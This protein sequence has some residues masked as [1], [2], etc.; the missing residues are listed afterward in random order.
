MAKEASE[1]MTLPDECLVKIFNFLPAYQLYRSRSVCQRFSCVTMEANTR[2]H[3]LVIYGDVQV[4]DQFFTDIYDFYH[5]DGR[6]IDYRLSSQNVSSRGVHLSSS[7]LPLSDLTFAKL[8]AVFSGITSLTI[9]NNSHSNEWSSKLIATLSARR[10]VTLKLINPFITKTSWSLIQKTLCTSGLQHLQHFYIS[11]TNDQ[12]ISLLPFLASISLKSLFI[13]CFHLDDLPHL[14]TAVEHHLPCLQYFSF[15]SSDIA[16]SLATVDFGSTKKK[17]LQNIYSLS[18]SIQSLLDLQLLVTKW[19]CLR[20]LHLCLAQIHETDEL[21]SIAECLCLLQSLDSLT[22]LKISLCPWYQSNLRLIDPS[23]MEHLPTL[24]QLRR[25]HFK[26]ILDPH[27]LLTLATCF[28]S[29]QIEVE[30]LV[31]YVR[32]RQ[33]LRAFCQLC[34]AHLLDRLLET[35][36]DDEEQIGQSVTFQLLN[37]TTVHCLQR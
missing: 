4:G 30:V 29:A 25:V 20:T 36:E 10:L 35:E 34:M 7:I 22:S 1:L 33:L 18:I 3:S 37:G 19:S 23:T 8:K 17:A 14:L 27:L 5:I 2:R 16:T 28:P 26:L 9:V 15:R 11:S 12:L 13:A 31:N 24:V 6:S 21:P 32:D